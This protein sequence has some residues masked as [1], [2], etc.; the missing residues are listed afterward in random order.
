MY[1]KIICAL[2]LLTLAFSFAL[3]CHGGTHTVT[4]NI[5]PG[6]HDDNFVTNDEWWTPWV[7]LDQTLAPGHSLNFNVI[8]QEPHYVE[9]SDTWV[10]SDESIHIEFGN[11][12][13]S[14]FGTT[15]TYRFWFTGITG[16]FPGPGTPATPI[17][18]TGNVLDG[19]NLN[20]ELTNSSFRFTDLHAE[21]TID[22]GLLLGS[23]AE[24]RLGVDSDEIVSTPEP[25]SM[26]IFGIGVAGFIVRG[27]MARRKSTQN[28][29]RC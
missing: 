1:K 7:T 15:F 29:D 28:R 3:P 27:R 10:P 16:D 20:L 5:V 19:V 25:A 23:V 13:G 24:V 9:L 8:F 11:L 26:A 14:D 6:A 22:D 18:G 21:I 12:R 2:S 17:T 4:L